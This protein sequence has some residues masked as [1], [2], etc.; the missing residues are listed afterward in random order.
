M[1]STDRN[2][3]LDGRRRRIVFV[4]AGAV[5]CLCLALFLYMATTGGATQA[6]GDGGESQQEGAGQPTDIVVKDRDEKA[7]PSGWVKGDDGTKRY[8]DP[9][10]HE[11]VGWWTKEGDERFFVDGK[12]EEP[13]K[14]W[15]ELEGKRYWLKPENG[16][17]A[18]HEWCE[19]DGLWEVFDD[20]G[21][22]IE[23]EDM[24]PPNDEE[25]MASMSER[26]QAVVASCE[27]TPWQGKGWCA[28]WV[29]QVFA[30]AGEAAP[31]G[32]ACDIANLYCT[33]DDLADLKP[34]M[35]V[36]VPS[37]PQSENG[38]IW[39]HVCIYVGEGMVMDNGGTST[40]KMRLGPWAAWFGA[41]HPAK[42]GW[43]SGISLE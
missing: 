1:E 13:K 2:E 41:S 36:A 3:G 38:K 22:W 42:W 11:L 34:G 43:N 27:T 23:G 28:A 25:N 33:S 16:A 30:N 4:A 31:G 20:D 35:V 15:L 39:G 12:S 26:Q 9:E 37:H 24:T 40:R 21:A 14:G 17:M 6:A 5:G 29:W 32:D 18:Q 8:Y 19:V 7:E 10:T